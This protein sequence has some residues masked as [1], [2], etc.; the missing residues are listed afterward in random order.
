MGEASEGKI[1]ASKVVAFIGMLAT[2]A[3][4]IN[5]FANFSLATPLYPLWGIICLALV[6]V[7]FISIELISF[8]PLKIPYLWWIL[9]IIGAVLIVLAYFFQITI[10][11]IPII[12]FS[13]KAAGHGGDGGNIMALMIIATHS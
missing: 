12:A 5:Y 13:H 11:A 7:L 8:G 4:A 3:L 6:V 1:S 2:F 9:L 10:K